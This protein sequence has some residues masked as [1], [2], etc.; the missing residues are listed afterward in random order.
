ME[1]KK[2][3]RATVDRI[4]QAPSPKP[5]RSIYPCC[6]RNILTESNLEDDRQEKRR[7]KFLQNR[8]A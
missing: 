3:I 1:A 4:N 2:Q 5:F 7:E 6:A 8:L